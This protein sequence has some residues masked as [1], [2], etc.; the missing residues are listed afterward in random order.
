MRPSATNSGIANLLDEITG[1]PL[2]AGKDG[3]EAVVYLRLTYALSGRPRTLVLRPPMRQDGRTS[4]AN[5]G[6]VVYHL[7]LPVIDFRYLG[8]E[9]VLDLDWE[10]PWFSRFRNRN[11][12]RQYDSPLAGFLY[13]DHFE[14]RKEVIVRPKDLQEWVDLGLTGKKVIP[15]ADQE[16]LKRRAAAFLAE[17]SPVTIDGEKV[18]GTL[19]RIHFLRRGLR[20]TGVIDPPEELGINA[21]ILGVIFVYPRSA[22]LPQEVTMTWDLF[23]A[24][25]RKVPAVASDEA[26]GLLFFVTPEDPVLRWQNF[27]QN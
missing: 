16:E 7:G 21:A 27:L 15:V 3:G 26:G 4:A 12:R 10:D 20:Q 24:K 1:Q 17:R 6:F 14:V 8:R 5:V 19:D 13:V 11:L 2:P 18:S 9:E 23:A 25:I 22:G